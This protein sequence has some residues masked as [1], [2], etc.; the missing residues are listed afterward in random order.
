MWVRVPQGCC[1]SQLQSLF[2]FS[3]SCFLSLPLSVTSH[4]EGP[5]GCLASLVSRAALTHATRARVLVVGGLLPSL[6]SILF[7]F[8]LCAHMHMFLHTHICICI[9]T[10]GIRALAGRALWPSSP[11][12]LGHS[13]TVFSDAPLQFFFAPK[14]LPPIGSMSLCNRHRRDSNSCG[15]SPMDFESISLAARTQ[16]L[17]PAG[18][19]VCRHRPVTYQPVLF[20]AF[21]RSACGPQCLRSIVHLA[22][23]SQPLSPAGRCACSSSSRGYGATAARLT[24]DQEVGSSSLSG[25]IFF[26]SPHPVLAVA[27]F[28]CLTARASGLPQPE[29]RAPL[30]LVPLAPLA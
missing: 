23:L 21:L 11:S 3:Y 15:Q 28:A 6:P 10:E 8:H 1:P 30:Q 27:F 29:L 20:S 18:D 12:L 25:L 2:G 4:Q 16:C 24:P 19:Q 22:S 26:L 13:D 17:L 14:K 7:S 9:S 5:T